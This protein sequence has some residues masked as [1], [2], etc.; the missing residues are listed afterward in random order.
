MEHGGRQPPKLIL[1]MLSYR[2]SMIFEKTS[3][4]FGKIQVSISHLSNI[5]SNEDES[6]NIIH[7]EI[8][9]IVK[10]HRRYINKLEF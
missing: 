4:D 3:L 7:V 6:Q 8:L 5:V 9:G 10:K 1:L 2:H